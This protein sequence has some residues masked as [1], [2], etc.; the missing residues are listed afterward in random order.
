MT[1][2]IRLFA[3]KL[4][5]VKGTLIYCPKCR[6][7]NVSFGETTLTKHIIGTNETYAVKCT[8]CNAEGIITE[9]WK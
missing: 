9:C 1:K 6:S 8:D 7:A 4:L 2:W 3:N 5:G